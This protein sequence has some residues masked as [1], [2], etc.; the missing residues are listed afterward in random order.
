MRT[1][2]SS[3]DVKTSLHTNIAVTTSNRTQDGICSQVVTLRRSDA[4]EIHHQ[5]YPWA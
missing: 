1:K 4:P 2:V 3:P 5:A